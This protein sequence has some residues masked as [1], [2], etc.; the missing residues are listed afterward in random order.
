MLYILMLDIYLGWCVVSVS[1]S[2]VFIDRFL[3][4]NWLILL[5]RFVVVFLMFW[6]Y[7]F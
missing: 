5:C 7:C 2:I 6:Y 4:N 3:V 1:V